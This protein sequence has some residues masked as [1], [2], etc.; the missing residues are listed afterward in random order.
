[1]VA[2]GR[3]RHA[4]RRE[5][6]L[7]QDQP[8]EHLFLCCAGRIKVTQV[9]EEGAEIILRVITPGE[10]FG[11]F[12]VLIDVP[13]PATAEALEASVALAWDRA[14]LERL[15]DRFPRLAR[16]LTTIL[17][18]RLREMED[19][20]RELATERVSQRLARTLLRLTRLSGRRVEEGVLLDLR[21]SREELA[22][23]SGTTLFS[24]SRLLSD[25]R[26]RGL[27]GSRRGRIVIRDS[28]GL[29]TLAD[30]LVTGSIEDAPNALR[31]KAPPRQARGRSLR[32]R[33][34][35]RSTPR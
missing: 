18:R 24:V 10:I 3:E 16:N 20:L 35:G 7:R 9:S 22:Q 33:N 1:V 21:L 31:P 15:L 27:V 11:G 5:V 28:H 26:A 17:A 13:Y 30:E 6:F 29:V 32:Q 2:C 34:E 4:S 19:R 23:M 12:G 8:S 25:W 14:R